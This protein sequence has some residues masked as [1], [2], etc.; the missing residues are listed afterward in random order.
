M[1]DKHRQ[2]TVIMLAGIPCSGKSTW[3]KENT[4]LLYEKYN[5]APMI[6]LSKDYYREKI[7]APQD[8]KFTKENEDAV[9][10]S[11]YTQLG[12]VL[13]IPNAVVILDNTHSKP[14]H[15]PSYLQIFERLIQE[16]KLKFYIKVFDPPFFLCSIRN[17]YRRVT[18]GKYITPTALRKYSERFKEINFSQYK[19]YFYES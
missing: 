19:Q 7:N 3:V 15:I 6:T 17:H 13:S 14:H 5:Q 12:R 9:S 16:N 2:I 1:V 11:F 10:K 4:P 18:T 8:Y